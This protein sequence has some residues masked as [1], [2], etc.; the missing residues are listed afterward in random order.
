MAASEKTPASAT[1]WY[2]VGATFVLMIP[3]LWVHDLP[4]GVRVASIA[5]GGALIA[6][7]IRRLGREVLPPDATDDES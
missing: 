3:M 4:W 6:I 2:F 5:L 1:V 7:G